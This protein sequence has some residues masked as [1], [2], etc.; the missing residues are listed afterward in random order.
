MSAPDRSTRR[1]AATASSPC[2]RRG[3]RWSWPSRGVH[4]PMLAQLGLVLL[5]VRR[6]RRGRRR[7]GR[8]GRRPHGL[9][10]VRRLTAAA[11]DIAR[12][13]DLDPIK[14]EGDDEI[15]RLATAFN[16]MLA[17]LA[18]SR[19][20]QRQLVADAGHELR[21]PLTSLRTNLDLLAPGRRGER[22]SAARGARRA[23]RRRP[24]PGRGAHHPGRRPGRAGPRRAADPRSSRSTSPTSSP[25]RSTRVRRR[26]PGL[27]FDA[28]ARVV[29]G[30]RRGAGARARGDQPARQRRQVEPR[31]RHR[32]GPAQRRRAHRRRPGTRHPERRP[33]AR[34]RPVLPLRGPHPARVRA[35]ACRS[36][37]RRP[38]GTAAPSRWS[39]G[40]AAGRG[41]RSGCRAHRPSRTSRCRHRASQSSLLPENH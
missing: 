39:A 28:D 14:V 34:L 12:T 9:R 2:R 33:A 38:S 24:R 21:T 29:V 13:E 40:R 17:A 20:R 18:A 37:G 31:R 22:R 7:H 25:A 36:C 10:P 19:D 27:T 3:T 16:A 41:S 8:L 32:H 23:D 35:S 26:A 1:R 5:L 6:R 11:E 4:E 30:H 15:A